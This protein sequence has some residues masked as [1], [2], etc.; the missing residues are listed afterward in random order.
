MTEIN[1]NFGANME[2]EI[3]PQQSGSQLR[4][5]LDPTS[6][7]ILKDTVKEFSP[8]LNRVQ[9]ITLKSGDVSFDVRNS[10]AMSVSSPSA[11]SITT[12][13]NGYNGQLLVE[14]KEILLKV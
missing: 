12:M 11:V 1:F 7:G 14:R 8:E 9:A 6:V 10:D 5:P 3:N 13:T 2:E 4:Y